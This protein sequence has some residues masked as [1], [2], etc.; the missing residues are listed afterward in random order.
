MF[1]SSSSF[2]A[3]PRSRVVA[4]FLQLATVLAAPPLAA[5]LLAAALLPTRATAQPRTAADTTRVPDGPLRHAWVL[6]RARSVSP[7][8]RALRAGVDAARA[9]VGAAAPLE[10]PMVMVR[11]WDL[12]AD[13]VSRLPSQT[14]IMAQQSVPL[15]SIRARREDVERANTREAEIT[16]DAAILGVTAEADA[17]YLALWEAAARVASATELVQVTAQLVPLVEARL[18]TG[19]VSASELSL[20]RAVVARSLADL[21]AA[22]AN[23]DARRAELR[24]LLDLPDGA[25]LPD[26][27]EL[28]ARGAALEL[29]ALTREA[30]SS[31]A[32]VRYGAAA[33]ARAGA[34]DAVARASDGPVLTVGA[35]VML[36]P[37]DGLGWMLET[38]L[39]L[40]IWRGARDARREEAA[41]LVREADAGEDAW[42]IAINR[43]VTRAY[44]ACRA[45]RARHTA[46]VNTVLPAYEER[47]A[48]TLASYNGA[49]SLVGVVDALRDLTAL[50]GEVVGALAELLRVEQE[51]MHAIGRHE[52]TLRE[53]A[54]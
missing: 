52:E 40:P 1:S 29:A 27:P 25:E 14:M 17:A 33:R 16:R 3:R 30:M 10:D 11:V 8:L 21:G 23:V 34:L 20:A 7:R 18:A 24:V 36:M 31:R 6:A 39:T 51:L 15:S 26:P 50:R 4:I 54:R 12:P 5:T 47:R 41:A 35:G 2:T 48:V 49:G 9:R 13:V 44:E 42:R 53:V 37:H 19:D 28:V 45:A 46:L 32:E 43:E 22:R 38:G